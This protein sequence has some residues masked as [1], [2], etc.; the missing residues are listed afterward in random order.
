MYI[1]C[2]GR[3]HGTAGEAVAGRTRRVNQS[4]L[5]DASACPSLTQAGLRSPSSTACHP[6]MPCTSPSC[7]LP[8]L[9]HL[10]HVMHLT[11]LAPALC[12]PSAHRA[13]VVC[14]LA[15][16]A[17]GGVLHLQGRA[18]QGRAGQGRAV[19]S[20]GKQSVCTSLSRCRD[21][22][23]L[24]P[25][26]HAASRSSRKH[27]PA[28]SRGIPCAACICRGSSGTDSPPPLAP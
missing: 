4:W 21:S 18:G 12:L 22:Q 14:D 9:T 7:P 13:V 2:R 16:V 15:E 17:L 6:G 19:S 20:S 27:A 11:Q 8:P 5:R 28:G 25:N 10:R 23:P 3:G 1:G 26:L 24:P